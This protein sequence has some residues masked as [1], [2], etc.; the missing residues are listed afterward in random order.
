VYI[1]ASTPMKLLI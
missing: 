1:K